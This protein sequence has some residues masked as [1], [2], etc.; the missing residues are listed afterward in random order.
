MDELGM[1][2][3][4]LKRAFKAATNAFDAAAQCAQEKLLDPESAQDLRA[5]IFQVRD[6]IMLLMGHYRNEWRRRYGQGH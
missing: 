1:T 4:Y 2:I 6:G 5:R 3:A